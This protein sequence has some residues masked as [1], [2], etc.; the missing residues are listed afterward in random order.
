MKRPKINEKDAGNGQFFKILLN[1]ESTDEY[2]LK[3][4]VVKDFCKLTFRRF[5]P[6]T[7][8]AVDFSVDLSV[9]LLGD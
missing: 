6:L 4:W 7:S 2:T 5:E 8:R 3:L 9:N 1:N